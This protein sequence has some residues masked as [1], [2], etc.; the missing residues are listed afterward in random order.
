MKKIIK[1]VYRTTYDNYYIIIRDG[2]SLEAYEG[3]DLCPADVR[4]W[5]EK[6]KPIEL[7]EYYYNAISYGL[8]K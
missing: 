7:D 4:R 2:K 8:C 3:K 1:N 5:L 6:N